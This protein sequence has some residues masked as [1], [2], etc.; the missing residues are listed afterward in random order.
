MTAVDSIFKDLSDA[1]DALLKGSELSLSVAI[2]ENLRKTLLLSAASYFEWQLSNSV[3]DFVDEVTKNNLMIG[4]LVKSKAINRQFH[5]WFDWKNNSAA[6]FYALFGPGFRDHMNGKIK[7][8]QAIAE[9]LQAFLYIGAT[10][11][12]LVHSDYATYPIEKTPSEIYDLYMKAIV[13]VDAASIELRI[14]SETASATQ[15]T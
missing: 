2:E 7:V 6:P 1:A 9:G 13:F 4:T 15:T 8:D 5:T 10:R 12:L 14:C 11:N 3:R